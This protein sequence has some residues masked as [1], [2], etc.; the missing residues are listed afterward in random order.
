MAIPCSRMV[1]Q[2]LMLHMN[3]YQERWATAVVP[4]RVRRRVVPVPVETA[5][6]AIVRVTA[7]DEETGQDPGAFASASLYGYALI[8]D[9]Y[10]N[11]EG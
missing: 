7:D 3:E 1:S 9:C 6:I 11:A 10:L 2:T 5:V 8:F 4:V